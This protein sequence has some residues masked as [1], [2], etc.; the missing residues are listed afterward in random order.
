MPQRFVRNLPSEI[1]IAQLCKWPALLL[2]RAAAFRATLD[3]TLRSRDLS[4]PAA[5][6]LISL[7]RC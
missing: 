5:S 6:R 3:P 7:I 4:L 1:T 2:T